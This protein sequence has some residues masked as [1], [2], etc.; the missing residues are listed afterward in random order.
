MTQAPLPNP[1]GVRCSRCGYDLTGSKI[2]NVCPECGAPIAPSFAAA[3]Q[4]TS[5]FAITSLVLGIVSIPVCFCYGIPSIVCG[6]LGITFWYLTKQQLERNEV[7]GA[8]QSMALAGLICGII[9]ASLGVLYI[10]FIIVMFAIGA[11]AR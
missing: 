9:G 1:T 4:R 7:G 11:F 5:G 2:G 6:G 8:S 10:V 3:G